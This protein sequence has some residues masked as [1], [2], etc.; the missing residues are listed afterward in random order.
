MPRRFATAL[1]VLALPAAVRAQ[2]PEELLSAGTQVYVRWDGIEAHKTAYAETALG[3]MLQGDAGR[4]V[5]GAYKQ[6]Q[7]TLG[8]AVT[9][10]S[11][12]GGAAPDLLEKLQADAAEAPKLLGVLGKNGFV[13]AVEVHGIE[14]PDIQ[15]TLILPNAGATP[16]PFLGTLRLAAA[17]AKQDVKEE[18]IAGRDVAHLQA[19]PV[20]VAWWVEGKHGVVTAGIMPA[21]AVVKRMQSKKGSLADSAL[22]RRVKQ[23]KQFETGTRAFIDVAALAKFGKARGPE[24]A[25]IIDDLGLSGL[26]SLV[27]YSGF[28]GRAE[29]SLVEIDVSG[30]RKGLL[31]LV[32]GKPFTLDDAP[33]LPDDVVS[34]SMTNLDLAAL[35]DVGVQAAE[36]I[37]KLA[38]PDAAAQVKEVLQRIDTAL[39]VNVRQDLLGNLGGQ[40]VFYSSP[41]DGPFTLGQTLMLKVK[42]PDKLR[43]A[44]DQAIRGV[45]QAAGAEV[46][47]KKRKYH[48]AELREVHVKQQ[49]FIFVP[50][51][52]IHQGWLV[53]GYFPQQVQGYVLRAEGI[54]PRWKPDAAVQAALKEMPREFVALSVSDPR[55]TVRQVLSIAPLVGGAVNSFVPDVKFDVGLI[56][57]SHEVSRHLFPNVTAVYATPG[58]FRQEAR[59]S[60]A[61][62]IDV[63]G[64]DSYAAFFALTFVARI[65]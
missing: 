56:P 22:F 31:N 57:N 46:S 34:W 9:M 51:F 35:H 48:G 61:L 58:G 21:D 17:V 39:G 43:D 45:G 10:Q 20:Q 15:L 13:V 2:E 27:F 4:F 37:A 47:V 41:S 32:G 16:K 14:P 40:V 65:R 8:A 50:T 59:A 42:D 3:Q 26:K 30:P 18:K 49:G 28:A 24:V 11:L 53:V 19:G 63:T 60:L 29:R 23:F 33:P 25:K 1:L 52:T 64:L 12:L 38:A 36:Q 62:P 44:L 54:V 5:A 6:V 55:P 7:D